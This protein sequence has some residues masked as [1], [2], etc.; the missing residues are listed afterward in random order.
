MRDRCSCAEECKDYKWY[1]GR[2]IKVCDKWNNSFEE[3]FKDMGP[4]PSQKHSIDR[5]NNDGNYEPGNCRR[6]TADVQAKNKRN[7]TGIVCSKSQSN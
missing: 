2:G 1:A 3:F 7:P 6:T 4:R 5:I